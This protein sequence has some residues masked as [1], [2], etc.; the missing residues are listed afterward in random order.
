MAEHPLEDPAGV[1]P[2]A[3]VIPIRKDTSFEHPLD[4]TAPKPEP[5]H[6][7]DGIEFRDSAGNACPIIPEHLRTLAGIWSAAYKYIDAA[8]FHSAFHLLR[9]P[10]YLALG[11]VWAVVGVGRLAKA[12][13]ASGGG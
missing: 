12:G 9:S 7:G 5:V 10:M 6:D 11:V 3:E 13:S 4:E 8:R 1:E 2:D